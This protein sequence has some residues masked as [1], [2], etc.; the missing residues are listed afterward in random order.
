M[1]IFHG[2]FGFISNVLSPNL[3][4]FRG[5]GTLFRFHRTNFHQ[6]AF[7]QLIGIFI[8]Y[9]FNV[10]IHARDVSISRSKMYNNHQINSDDRLVP[11]SLLIEKLVVES[12]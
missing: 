5:G 10:H 11:W 9:N 12:Q 1:V 6:Y 8:E 7:Q 3:S 4:G 2:M